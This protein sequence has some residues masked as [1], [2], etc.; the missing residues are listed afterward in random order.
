MHGAPPGT[1]GLQCQADTSFITLTALLH[2]GRLGFFVLQAAYECE[3]VCMF[4][5]VCVCVCV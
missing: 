2:L 5:C 4:L 1:P 3:C